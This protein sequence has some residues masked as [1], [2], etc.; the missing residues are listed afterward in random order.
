MAPVISPPPKRDASS[1][2]TWPDGEPQPV[3]D[4]YDVDR[5]RPN[6]LIWKG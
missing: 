4:L 3:R 5:R 2:I 1:R 6:P